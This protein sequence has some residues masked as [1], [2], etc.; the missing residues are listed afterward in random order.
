MNINIWSCHFDMSE[1]YFKIIAET[2]LNYISFFSDFIEKT[3]LAPGNPE[4]EYV[5][6]LRIVLSSSEDH[7]PI[8]KK[9]FYIYLLIQLY[10]AQNF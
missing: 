1:Q 8:G 6:P 5:E 2:F 10:V 7:E 4:I 3:H 9:L